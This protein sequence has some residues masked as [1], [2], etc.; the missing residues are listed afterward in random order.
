MEV[1]T[2]FQ[3]VTLPITRFVSCDSNLG[4]PPERAPFVGSRPAN[5]DSLVISPPSSKLVPQ[6]VTFGSDTIWI[7]TRQHEF[8][9]CSTI[10]KYYL[11]ACMATAGAS[12]HREDFL[13]ERNDLVP[14]SVLR[15]REREYYTTNRHAESGWAEHV[16]GSMIRWI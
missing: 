9:P 3:L 16:D 8:S 10:L 11:H 12:C 15:A 14:P 6:A 7:H 5:V 13:R 2:A 1:L 4:T